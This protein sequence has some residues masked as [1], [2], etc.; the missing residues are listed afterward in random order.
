MPAASRQRRAQLRPIIAFAGLDL[1]VLANQA[2]PEAR[3]V[4]LYGV[5]LSI[6]T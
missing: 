4:P 1:G 6:Q 2:T 3:E 5:P